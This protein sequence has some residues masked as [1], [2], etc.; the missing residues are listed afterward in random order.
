MNT[1]LSEAADRFAELR[2]QVVAAMREYGVPGVALG[3]IAGDEE[4]IAGFGI[5]NVEHPLA[6]NADTLFQ[7]GSTTKTITGTVVMRLVE[8]GRL[9]LDTPVRRYVPELALQAVA[10]AEQ[11]TLRHLLSHTAGWVGDFFP[12]TGSG[13][14]ALARAVAALADVPQLTPLGAVWSYNNAAFYLVGRIIE[15]V[16]GRSYEQA[17][18]ELLLDPLGMSM[19]FFTAGEA[20]VHR[21][22]AGHRAPLD[23]PQGRAQV[24]QPWEITRA[25]APVGRLISTAHDQL[26]YARFHLGDGTTTDG[27]RLLSRELLAEMHRPF[28]A[29]AD[30]EQGAITWFVRG[31][32]KQRVLRHGGATV[33]QLSAFQFVPEQQFAITV[34]TNA[35]RGSELNLKIVPA[36]LKLFC[37]IASSLPEQLDLPATELTA[38]AGEYRAAL[39]HLR[40]RVV[41]EQ[42]MLEVLPQGGFPTPDTPP[43]PAPPPMRARICVGDRLLVLDAPFAN[44]RGE[45]LR[46]GQGNIEWLRI[47]GRIHR[48]M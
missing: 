32:G 21:V 23:A 12:D 45:F 34:L 43:P 24:L 42:L 47:G 22:V 2:E 30:G 13:D 1:G 44:A 48:R 9:D 6:V 3:I 4:F 29:A 25:S 16:T 19:S 38:F 39:R 18:R 35:D 5:T 26:K 7:I 37:G 10:V 15:K 46:D 33:G 20:I 40:L 17:T 31:E 8:Q 41:D 36:A 11:V 14:D 27:T 28:V